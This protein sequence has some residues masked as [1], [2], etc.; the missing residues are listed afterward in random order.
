[1]HSASSLR[2]NTGWGTS[3]SARAQVRK[4]CSK[5]PS[6]RRSCPPM[7]AI[8]EPLAAPSVDD[9][10]KRMAEKMGW[11]TLDNPYEYRPERGM[12]I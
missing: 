5:Q 4:L 10:N 1:M 3:V 9:Y 8:A 2:S 7:R 11:T 6:F 12:H